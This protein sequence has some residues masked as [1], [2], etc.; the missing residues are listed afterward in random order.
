MIWVRY[1]MGMGAGIVADRLAGTR[2]ARTEMKGARTTDQAHHANHGAY[3]SPVGGSIAPIPGCPA[4]PLMDFTD[5]A[6]TVACQAV[7]HNHNSRRGGAL[8]EAYWYK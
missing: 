5:C 4:Y 8:A 7:G 6:G 2:R 1:G 3:Q